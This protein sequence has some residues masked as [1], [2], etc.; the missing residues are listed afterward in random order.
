MRGPEVGV[1]KAYVGLAPDGQ[2]GITRFANNP[3]GIVEL[4]QRLQASNVD[5]IVVDAT[6][7]YEGLL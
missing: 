3:S 7:E 1:S 5:Q 2:V 6:G 4:V